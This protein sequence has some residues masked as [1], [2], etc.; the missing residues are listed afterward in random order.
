MEHH[1]FPP[2]TVI[3]ISK[4][5]LLLLPPVPSPPH[6]HPRT[7]HTVSTHNARQARQRLL[8]NL[9]RSREA[10]AQLELFGSGI[11]PEGPSQGVADGG[12]EN[13]EGQDGEGSQQPP[14]AAAAAGEKM[15]GGAAGADRVL[16]QY[17]D[18]TL[19]SGGVISLVPHVPPAASTTPP[20][21]PLGGDGYS[22]FAISAE[23]ELLLLRLRSPSVSSQLPQLTAEASGG[24]TTSSHSQQLTLLQLADEGGTPSISSHIDGVMCAGLADLGLLQPA[25]TATAARNADSGG[26]GAMP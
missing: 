14:T 12:L 15:A 23:D 9:R 16:L 25:A 1:D 6:S 24:G 13:R 20:L 5:E 19:P 18:E 22:P 4:A 3:Q 21:P 10:S 11:P 7:F 8:G 26:S 17:A 2:P